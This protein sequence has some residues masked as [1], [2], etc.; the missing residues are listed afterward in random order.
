MKNK[1]R[2]Q[3]KLEYTSTTISD[4]L[5][6]NETTASS[7]GKAYLGRKERWSV[8]IHCTKMAIATRNLEAKCHDGKEWRTNKLRTK[9]IIK[10]LS[11]MTI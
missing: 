8:F 5:L 6:I 1:G 11:L 2:L 3:T 10:E 7:N 4:T 9:E